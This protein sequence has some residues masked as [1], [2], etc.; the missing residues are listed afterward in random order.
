VQA[1]AAEQALTGKLQQ[2]PQWQQVRQ[3]LQEKSQEVMH[4]RKQLARYQPQDVPSA[5]G[6]QSCVQAAHAVAARKF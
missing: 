5:D 3:L 4:L 2:T 6:V 1:R